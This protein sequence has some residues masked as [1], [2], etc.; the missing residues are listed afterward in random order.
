MAYVVSTG[1]KVITHI[2]PCHLDTLPPPRVPLQEIELNGV[3]DWC[4]SR[5]MLPQRSRHRPI[6]LPRLRLVPL[7]NRRRSILVRIAQHALDRVVNT[8][9]PHMMLP[10]TAC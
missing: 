10:L 7:I 3:L 6:I 1:V 8:P 4:V 9:K 2:T 5:R